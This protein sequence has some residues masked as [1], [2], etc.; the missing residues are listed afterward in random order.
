M[1]TLVD[2]DPP[3]AAKL[4]KRQFWLLR[5]RQ[6]YLRVDGDPGSTLYV[7]RVGFW[8]AKSEEWVA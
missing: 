5:H 1:L 8:I 4:P 3:V 2:D 7:C 6:S